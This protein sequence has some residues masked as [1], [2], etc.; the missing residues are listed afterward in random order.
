[1]SVS[2]HTSQ[3]ALSVSTTE[4]SLISGTSSLQND[5][6]AGAY[7]L[8]LDASNMVKGDEFV[9]RVY[10]AVRSGGTKRVFFQ[11]VLSDAQSQL[12]VMPAVMLLYS[13]DFTIQRT[14]GADRAFDTSID[15]AS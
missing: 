15:R 4:L 1:M 7:Q 14:A 10:K 6:T 11:A 3:T 5:N 9:I 12:F 8:S 13:W 2:T